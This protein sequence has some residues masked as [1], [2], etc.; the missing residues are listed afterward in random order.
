MKLNATYEVR[1]EYLY[2][3]AMGEFDPTSSQN[4]FYEW[5]EKAR[6]HNLKRALCDITLVTGLDVENT[7]LMTRFEISDFIARSIPA[8]FRLAVLENPRQL[9]ADGFDENV[10]VN[11]G[12]M[13]KIT[14]NLQ[15]ALEWLGVTPDNK[16]NASDSQ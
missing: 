2:V 10:M 11:R 4:L 3:K 12:V 8:G 15:E 9:R 13:V 7:S 5:T 6:K 16:G 14:S 1:D